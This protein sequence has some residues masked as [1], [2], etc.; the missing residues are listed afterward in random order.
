MPPVEP[1]NNEDQGVTAPDP[2]TAPLSPP[3]E[4]SLSPLGDDETNEP[5]LPMT[6]NL[7]T[8]PEVGQVPETE[9]PT[10]E[11]ND[12]PTLGSEP[13]SEPSEP[14]APVEPQQ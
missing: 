10:P 5:E 6:P 7:S 12:A 11:T 13:V 3:N 1:E 8:E 4:P 14:E 9:A 2:S